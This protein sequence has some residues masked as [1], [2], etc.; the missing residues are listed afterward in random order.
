MS[1]KTKLLLTLLLCLLLSL[2]LL[3]VGAFADQD[4]PVQDAVAET[5]EAQPDAGVP[6]A[7][8]PDS[9]LPDAAPEADGLTP[10]LLSSS[11][12]A[13]G[14]EDGGGD[15]PP[16]LRSGSG[17][18]TELHVGRIDVYDAGMPVAGAVNDPSTIKINL[19]SSSSNPADP[20]S[21]D[22]AYSYMPMG[23]PEYMTGTEK[24]SSSYSYT[25]EMMIY[26]ADGCV[27]PDSLSASSVYFNGI[28]VENI[29]STCLL[30][31]DNAS[32]MLTIP[33]GYPKDLPWGW[34]SSD[35]SC[36]WTFN[37]DNGKLILDGNSYTGTDR[38]YESENLTDADGA[39]INVPWHA[40]WHDITE[41][42]TSYCINE[43]QGDPFYKMLSLTS[44][45]FYGDISFSED[46]FYKCTNLTE[47]YFGGDLEITSDTADTFSYT[48]VR[49]LTFNHP[50][51]LNTRSF[52]YCEQ[53]TSVTFN[54][55]AV[56]SRA[57]SLN[58][59][60]EGS[61]VRTLTFNSTATLNQDALG[62][63][64]YLTTVTFNAPVTLGSKV[65]SWIISSQAPPVTRLDL[66]AGSVMDDAAFDNCP[67]CFLTLVLHDYD[68]PENLDAVIGETSSS[69]WL[70]VPAGR[71]SAYKDALTSDS[72]KNHVIA[73]PT[74][75]T[76]SGSCGDSATW[77]LD[78]NSYVLTISGTGT[79]TAGGW[80]YYQ[81]QI[82]S[83]VVEEGITGLY[84]NSL[85]NMPL[86]YSVYLP[87]TLT[88]VYEKAFANDTNIG[89][90]EYNG[91]P[92]EWS[93]KVSVDTWGSGANS[94]TPLTDYL[95]RYTVPGSYAQ[96]RI[97]NGGRSLYLYCD[98]AYPDVSG[99]GV[100]K[101]EFAGTITSVYVTEGVTSLAAST[102]D[103]LSN[104]SYA[105]LPVSLTSIG[106]NCFRGCASRGIS[107]SYNGSH[108][109]YDQ[110]TKGSGNTLLGKAG[111]DWVPA[112]LEGTWS[113]GIWYSY[114]GDLYVAG[115]G[116]IPSYTP[117][118]QP[119]AAALYEMESS[120]GIH[121]GYSYD[122]SGE[123]RL[124]DYGNEI[125][126]I[127]SYA[128]AGA[129][130]YE[131]DLQRTIQTIAANAFAGCA[132]ANKVNFQGS[133]SQWNNVAIA[134]GNEAILN[135]KE[136]SAHSSVNS[137]GSWGTNAMNGG[138]WTLSSGTLTV[139]G[140]GVMPDYVIGAQPWAGLESE[141]YC[142][143]V[144]GTVS[145]IG[146]NAFRGLTQ[147][148]YVYLPASLTSV[149]QYAFYANSVETVNFAGNWAQWDAVTIASGND[150]LLNAYID[151]DYSS[152]SGTWGS[153]SSSGTWEV[154][155]CQLTISGSGAIPA[156]SAGAQPWAPYLPEIRTVKVND[157]ITG[158]GARAFQGAC[159]AYKLTLPAG[160]TS[161]GNNAFDGWTVHPY[162]GNSYGAYD[163]LTF[164]GTIGQW[165]ALSKGS[166]NGWL[167]TVYSFS[168][169]SQSASGTLTNGGKE[170]SWYLSGS[171]LH[172][173]Y[174]YDG[175]FTIPTYSA[176]SDAPWYAYR[177][178]IKSVQMYGIGTVGARSF[179]G[180]TSLRYVRLNDAKIV[181]TLAFDGCTSLKEIQMRNTLTKINANA[182]RSCSA[183]S[184]ATY[185]GTLSDWAGVTVASG[186]TALT[187]VLC[188]EVGEDDNQ[189]GDGWRV[190]GSINGGTAELSLNIEPGSS[191]ATG[192]PWYQYRSLI[193]SIVM[194]PNPYWEGD[195]GL[196]NIGPNAFRGLSKVTEVT[197]PGTIKQVHENAFY[198][199]SALTTVYF[200]GTSAQWAQ[201]SIA[202][203]NAPLVNANV[204]CSGTAAAGDL[205][206]TKQ[207]QDF[208]G[209]VGA[210]IT[211][212]VGAS[213]S[214]LKY[215]WYVRQPGGTE[216]SKSTAASATTKTL[217]LTMKEES[218]GRQY[219]CIITDKYGNTAR[220]QT[221]TIH[222]G[223]A[224]KITTQPTDFYG[225]AGDTVTF[226][227]VATG[228]G[229]TYQ[230]WF[231]RP[232][233]TVFNK[234]TWDSGTKATYTMT[235]ADKYD[236]YQ[237]Y[238]VIT[239]SHG[240]NLRTNTVN[241]IKGTKLTITGQ[242]T[243]YTGK[244]GSTATFTVT[245]TGDDLTYQWWYCKAGETTYKQSTLA[246]GT[247]ATY[248]MTLQDKHDGWKYYCVI[249]DSHGKSV[250]SNTVKINVGT[251]L[252][253]TTQP[254][255]YAGAVG[256]TAK[257][258][259]KAQGDGLT[260]QWY[261][262][263]P[264]ATSF[265]K[266]T[267]APGTTANYSIAVQAKHEGYQ[268]YCIVKDSHGNSVKTN[269]VKIIIG[270]ELKITTQPVNYTG[271]VGT[272]A[273]FKVVAQGDGLT[274]Q[275]YY[276]TPSAASFSK[277][278]SA[279]GTTA[280]YSIAVQ[281][282]HEGYQFYCIVK[283]SHGS[284]VKTNTVKIFVGTPL[285][286]TTQPSNFTGAVGATAKLKVV[287]QGD[288]LTYQWYCKKTG[289]TS[290]SKSTLTSATTATLSL[291][292]Q[293][294]H[295][296]YQYYCK[297]KDSHGN[298][299]N[300][301]TV[302]ITVGTELKITT[303]PTNYTGA[304]GSTAKFKVVAQGDGLTYQW[305]YKTPSASSFSKC[306]SAP[307][308]T[309]NY[310]ITVQ[311][312]HEGYQFYCIVKDSHG[313]SVK[314]STVKIFVGTPLKI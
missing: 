230:W 44:A 153:G 156:Y 26:A 279:S 141:I 239:D 71:V 228:D 283:D 27:F 303:Q 189:Y 236:G 33:L 263:T 37:S 231:K 122:G 43:I 113:G 120:D 111:L 206:I 25:L 79:V 314:S 219:Y 69:L 143:K 49:N 312:K 204:V 112:T 216:F 261:Y 134:S 22:A 127:G 94:N 242:P 96:Y 128:F 75:D 196:Y 84:K 24:F 131:V 195:G 88:N 177:S 121:I 186:N 59:P 35:K 218:A 144:E 105:E 257:F 61:G 13:A 310:N 203:G 259:V 250:K 262:K 285:K 214:G 233:E 95:F 99:Y 76:M 194:Q 87:S 106:K 176:A 16:V 62:N 252:K 155:S 185:E 267:T 184:D 212:T 268:F 80:G 172:I 180:Y 58:G 7:D 78:L 129:P 187:D 51:D 36:W 311:S 166:G 102:F 125:T 117:G 41:V 119:W 208:T 246:S 171:Q 229:L 81:D 107:V 308:T 205:V 234:S 152:D 124:Y 245:A 266:C 74:G 301:S 93:S 273:K 306:T 265:S 271:A 150:N 313:S 161:I 67:D 287:A 207:P 15:D 307:G 98:G 179:Q 21:I 299:V 160:L 154:S 258:T 8:A 248:T 221:V 272:T 40:Y 72:R 217:E 34:A 4:D 10:M 163:R 192:E 73:I 199:C 227:A 309:A 256:S 224:F 115:Y 57:G 17:E 45:K 83:V 142:V 213:G 286:I 200:G 282:K 181:G 19:S 101:D 293:A 223:K 182:F 110:I 2:T 157:G 31:D 254:V 249:T 295:D 253:I 305:Y 82:Q 264:S 39:M 132:T 52:K 68:P 56:L 42:N 238:C 136:F 65:F 126:S 133:R 202:S 77:S 139:S 225:Q 191:T 6:D 188:W 140:A 304:V 274:Y 97:A 288:G 53:L 137:S 103:G 260:Y 92:A 183:L 30:I 148:D 290:F 173:S 197:L 158:I 9:D 114:Y 241:I 55:T 244:A 281:A 28:C 298:T 235:M 294:K 149:G 5:D 284:S 118:N 190:R 14:D 146:K 289:E 300:S 38:F 1:T 270:T 138:D 70:Y 11:P 23:R 50:A 226:K 164:G 116:D 296:G 135:C 63:M 85:A 100:W 66:P 29:A 251:P 243:N 255:N 302:K 240:S 86:L 48:G 232:G 247:K 275:W 91:T 109:Q 215:Q 277:C 201:V 292:L 108:A 210:E 291:T 32:L 3:P 60:F 47:L 151:I 147:V 168:C 175:T 278:T 198:G 297:V 167:D 269:T 276:K 46:A 178:E 130:L 211:F 20:V 237:Y 170:A 174:D 209:P 193:T 64:E 89:F 169:A 220:T 54:D 90:V 145:T 12:Q 222:K 159:R 280:N 165:D 104:L 162:D 18:A 123:D